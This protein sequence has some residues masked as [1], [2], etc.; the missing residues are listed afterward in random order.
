MCASKHDKLFKWS[1]SAGPLMIKISPKINPLVDDVTTADTTSHR[2]IN[3]QD[4]RILDHAQ[5][6]TKRKC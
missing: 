1:K 5:Q 3:A 2:L 6:Q 4:I